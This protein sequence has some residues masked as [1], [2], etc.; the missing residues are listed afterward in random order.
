M[1]HEGGHTLGLSSERRRQLLPSILFTMDGVAGVIG[2][3]PSLL[4]SHRIANA[5]GMPHHLVQNFLLVFT[6]YGVV[7]L[8]GL[9]GRRATGNNEHIPRWLTAVA[10]VVNAA[11]LGTVGFSLSYFDQNLTG[12][13]RWLL[14]GMLGMGTVVTTGLVYATAEHYRVKQD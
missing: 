9:G 8:L 7:V 13:G 2:G 6:S 5:V 11:F 1:A 4:F 12:P 10:L 3:V 14:R